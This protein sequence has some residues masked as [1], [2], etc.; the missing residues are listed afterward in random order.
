MFMYIVWMMIL[1]YFN[2]T[3]LKHCKEL[4]ITKEKQ[5]ELHVYMLWFKSALVVFLFPLISDLFSSLQL[6]TKRILVKPVLTR[7]HIKEVAKVPK[8]IYLNCHLMFSKMVISTGMK[9]FVSL[10]NF[11]QYSS[12]SDCAHSFKLALNFKLSWF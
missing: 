2:K 4:S 5:S 12:G 6:T 9:S 3:V 7:D 8:C 10:L 11:V 1:P